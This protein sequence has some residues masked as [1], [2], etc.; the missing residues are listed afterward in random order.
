MRSS[1]DKRPFLRKF[2]Q[3]SYGAVH[4]D[5]PRH[6]TSAFQGYFRLPSRHFTFTACITLVIL[7]ARCR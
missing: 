6:S 3:S 5:F 2:A 7:V 4:K 1:S